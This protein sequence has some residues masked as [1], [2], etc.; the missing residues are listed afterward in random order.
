MEVKE[1]WKVGE[2]VRVRRVSRSVSLSRHTTT[3]KQKTAQV[4]ALQKNEKNE[5]KTIGIICEF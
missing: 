1:E 2:A 4:L 3:K 5:K